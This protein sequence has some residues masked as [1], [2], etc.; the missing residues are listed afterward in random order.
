MT[1]L[2]ITN[3][4]NYVRRSF[5]KSSAFSAPGAHA[6]RSP[7][8]FTDRLDGLIDLVEAQ[9]PPS[10]PDP[11][12]KCATA[13]VALMMG[14]PQLARVETMRRGQRKFWKAGGRRP[15]SCGI[16]SARTER[17]CPRSVP[18]SLSSASTHAQSHEAQIALAVHQQKNRLAVGVTGGLHLGGHVLRGGDFLLRH[19][20]DHV[21]GP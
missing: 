9:L 18:F 1:A 14:T 4:S 17:G 10:P 20:D 8:A 3:V 19:L 12:R 2:S 5:L 15:S 21:A 13:V 7:E 16:G 11:R 6:G